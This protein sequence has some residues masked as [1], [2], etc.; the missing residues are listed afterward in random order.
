MLLS[1]L[2]AYFG[3]FNQHLPWWRKSLS[4]PLEQL[5]QLSLVF[6]QVSQFGEQSSHSCTAEFAYE[7]EGHC[8]TQELS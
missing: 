7:P 6:A 8:T 5:M 3:Q 4:L 2:F 1:V